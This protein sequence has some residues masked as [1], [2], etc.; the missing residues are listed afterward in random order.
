MKNL[1]EILYIQKNTHTII[2]TINMFIAPLT[3]YKKKIEIHY[4]F[5]LNFIKHL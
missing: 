2:I 4:S 3:E 1:Y 5:I